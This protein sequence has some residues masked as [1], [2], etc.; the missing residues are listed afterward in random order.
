MR[1]DPTSHSSSRESSRLGSAAP[2][3]SLASEAPDALARDVRTARPL[4]KRELGLLLALA[5]AAGALWLFVELAGEVREGTAL[6]FDRELLLAMRT[7]GDLS[8][9]VG[10]GWFEEM[11]RDFTAL[12]SM[13]VL[14]LVAIAVVGYLLISRLHAAALLVAV[15][16]GGGTLFS[17]LLKHAFDRTRPDLVPH[18]MDVYTASFPSGHSMLSAVTYLTLAALLMR[19][20]PHRRAR[21]YVVI[22][23]VVLTLLVGASRVYLGVHWP[24]D[25]LAGWAVGASWA[26]VC[27][28]AMLWLQRRG[29]VD[30]GTRNA[31]EVEATDREECRRDA[32]AQA[33]GSSSDFSR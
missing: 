23:A 6:A 16:V 33:G 9:P 15:A 25:V 3:R 26:I 12:G 27:W 5:I 2:A 19:L 29:Q 31:R 1:H 14:A 18:S 22:T 13:G 4:A 32:R 24:S 11:A 20:Q 21:V 10:P 17:T 7:P 28:A 8:D 30:A